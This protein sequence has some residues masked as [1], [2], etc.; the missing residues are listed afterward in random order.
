MRRSCR[1]SVQRLSAV[2]RSGHRRTAPD[3]YTAGLTLCVL[4][5]LGACIL[6]DRYGNVYFSAGAGISLS[7]T[8]GSGELNGGSSEPPTPAQ[9]RSFLTNSSLTFTGSAG[10]ASLDEQGGNVGKYGARDCSTDVA[11]SIGTA[12]VSLMYTY[13]YDL[14]NLPAGGLEAKPPPCGSPVEFRYDGCSP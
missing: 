6:V 9:T 13:G 14:S 3:Y 1:V 8:L 2:V 10:P 5:C 12:G 11:A 4:L 7:I